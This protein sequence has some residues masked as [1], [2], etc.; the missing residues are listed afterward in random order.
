MSKMSE[1]S[2]DIQEMLEDGVHPTA[3]A[4]RL[5]VPLGLVYDTLESMED[6]ESNTEVFSPFET[7]NS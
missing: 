5:D 4:K 1:L 3:I 7:M 2:I 6:E